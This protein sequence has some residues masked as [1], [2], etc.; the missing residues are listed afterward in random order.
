M[1][2]Q[3]STAV[4]IHGYNLQADGWK[5]VVSSRIQTGVTEAVVRQAQLIFWGSGAS[6]N[7]SGVKESVVTFR[8]ATGEL[9]ADLAK[10]AKVGISTVQR[11]E[12]ADGLPTV[13]DDLEWRAQAR[14]N[15]ILAIR[16]ALVRA[17]VTFLHDDGR[18]VG[19]RGK[20]TARK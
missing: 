3:T 19:V 7:E 5:E 20:L 6:K 16:E 14:N 4:L 2:S 12:A 11:I 18:G 15:S 13:S 9:L 1:H 17:G 10:K 8:L